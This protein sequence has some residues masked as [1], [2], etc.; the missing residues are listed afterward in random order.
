MAKLQQEKDI[1]PLGGR[2]ARFIPQ[3]KKLTNCYETLDMLHGLR[4]P[5]EYI[6]VQEKIPQHIPMKLHEKK[7]VTDKIRELLSDCCI[8]RCKYDPTGWVSNIFL[9]KKNLVVRE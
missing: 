3:W 1:Y 6:T 2:L 8:E 9:E 7:F 4:I 5:D